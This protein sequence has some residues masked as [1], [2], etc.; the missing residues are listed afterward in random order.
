M[1]IIPPSVA[2]RM[3]SPFSGSDSRFDEK[4]YR[5]DDLARLRALGREKVRLLIKDEPGVMKFRQGRKKAHTMY[6]VP[7]SV[8]RRIYTRLQNAA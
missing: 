1:Y 6:S 4:H 7:E 3:H 2:Q 5:I 8:A